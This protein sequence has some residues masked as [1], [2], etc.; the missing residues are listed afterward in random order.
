MDNIFNHLKGHQKLIKYY[1]PEE[2][3][4]IEE[5]AWQL[6]FKM[7]SCTPLTRSSYHA[8]EH[9]NMLRKKMP[10]FENTKILPYSDEQLYSIIIN[11]EQYPEFLPWCKNQ[12]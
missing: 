1:S 8:D 5:K 3:K 7:V 10:R 6:G 2:F 9:F 12:K 4:S 11:V